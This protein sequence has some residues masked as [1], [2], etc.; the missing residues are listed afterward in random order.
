MCDVCVAEMVLQKT[1]EGSFYEVRW[2]R[3]SRELE[4]AQEALPTPSPTG[5]HD[6][7]APDRGLHL[8]AE[9]EASEF[10]PCR[11]RIRVEDGEWS[12][13][14]E[15]Q[16]LASMIGRIGADVKWRLVPVELRELMLGRGGT[17]D[18]IQRMAHP[19]KIE[20]EATTGEFPPEVA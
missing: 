7:G 8:Q 10:K 19:L 5:D 20:G 3:P 18:V 9:G 14:V 2:H 11:I 16:D 12:P 6:L 1:Q 17:T 13:W 15:G 4:Q